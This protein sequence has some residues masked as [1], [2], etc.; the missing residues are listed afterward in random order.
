MCC[1]S[2][3][4][5]SKPKDY[6]GRRNAKDVKNIL[7]QMEVCFDGIYIV[8]KAMKVRTAPC[9]FPTVLLFGGAESMSK[10]KRKL[11]K[12]KHG[13]EYKKELKRQLYT[14]NVVYETRKKLRELKHTRTVREY[15]KEFMTHASNPKHADDVLCYFLDGCASW[16]R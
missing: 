5:Y 1:C 3:I 9:I 6:N 7:W 10:R 8:D 14:K 2:R 12:L 16:V 11:A 13:P 15:V 4:E